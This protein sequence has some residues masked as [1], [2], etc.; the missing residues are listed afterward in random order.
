MPA[1]ALT[2]IVLVTRI[3]LVSI[4]YLTLHKVLRLGFTYLFG[5]HMYPA[6]AAVRQHTV[7]ALSNLTTVP[8]S[9]V[10]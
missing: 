9:S 4:T 8:Q 2:N 10:S 5:P 3:V 7:R 1:S 6:V